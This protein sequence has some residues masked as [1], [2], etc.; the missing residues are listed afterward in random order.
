LKFLGAISLGNWLLAINVAAYTYITTRQIKAAII[1]ALG[2]W[3]IY[4]L[5]YVYFSSNK[6]VTPEHKNFLKR[7]PFIII[8][9]VFTLALIYLLVSAHV[10]ILALL[11]LVFLCLVYAL[12]FIK[13]LPI[14][15]LLLSSIWVLGCLAI[16]KTQPLLA[17]SK[18]LWAKHIFCIIL[19][20]S[21]FFDRFNINADKLSSIKTLAAFLPKLW[22]MLGILIIQFIA[23]AVL[24]FYGSEQFSKT[25]FLIPLLNSL[26]LLAIN[27][28]AKNYI[29]FYFF[30]DLLLALQPFALMLY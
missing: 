25:I 4:Y 1:S 24:F 5:H 27:N 10:N 6:F 30:A 2:V 28:Y 29:T 23:F 13:K 16:H 14:K 11:L 8:A 15:N 20:F 17:S 26:A 3:L 12:P 18:T 21:L 22:L 9:F 7:T 19:A